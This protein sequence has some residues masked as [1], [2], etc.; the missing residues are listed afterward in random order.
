MTEYIHH[1]YGSSYSGYLLVPVVKGV[2]GE[3]TYVSDK[4]YEEQNNQGEQEG[5][6]NTAL[7]DEIPF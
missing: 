5:G 7:D 3:Q 1:G 6:L 4:E 2:C